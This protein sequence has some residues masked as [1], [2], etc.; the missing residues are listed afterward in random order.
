MTGFISEPTGRNQILKGI[1]E[2]ES[3]V[4]APQRFYIEEKSN[5]FATP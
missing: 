2:A 5:L 4:I 1:S 3:I